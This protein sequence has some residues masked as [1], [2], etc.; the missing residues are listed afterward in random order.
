[1]MHRYYWIVFTHIHSMYISNSIL[2]RRHCS[3]T[4]EMIV[5]QLK[6]LGTYFVQIFIFTHHTRHQNAKSTTSIVQTKETSHPSRN[7]RYSPHFPSLTLLHHP[8]LQST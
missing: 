4:R 2:P 3:E 7:I 1:M 8:Y 5:P 6:F